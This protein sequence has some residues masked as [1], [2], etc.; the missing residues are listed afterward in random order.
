M[1][2]HT[3]KH[4]RPAPTICL[5]YSFLRMEPGSHYTFFLFLRRMELLK[6]FKEGDADAF[7]TLFRQFQ[8]DTE[9]AFGSWARR[10][11]T[12]IEKKDLHWGA[13][14]DRRA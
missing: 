3:A 6:R 12:S 11:A 9:A 2:P 7:E 8:A 13:K 5:I 14:D 1:P 4:T 10:I